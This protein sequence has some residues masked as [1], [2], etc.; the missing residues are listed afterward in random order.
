[1]ASSWCWPTR[2]SRCGAEEEK[3]GTDGCP[4][5][6]DPAAAVACCPLQSPASSR[7][8][9]C[10]TASLPPRACLGVQVLLALKRSNLIKK[11]KEENV[12][13]NMADAGALQAVQAVQT[14]SLLLPPFLACCILL[15]AV[16]PG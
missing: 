7:S 8:S 6:V 15:H 14:V 13:V 16:E 11:I 12:H 3:E 4:R 5:D 9:C 10:R 2:P 1:M